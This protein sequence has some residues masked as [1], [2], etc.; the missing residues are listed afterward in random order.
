[1][2]RTHPDPPSA[3]FGLG[4]VLRVRRRVTAS[5]KVYGKT[6]HTQDILANLLK[7]RRDKG[8]VAQLGERL[9]CK[10]EAIGSIPFTSTT[11]VVWRCGKARWA[12]ERGQ[13]SHGACNIE[14]AA[15]SMQLSA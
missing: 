5:L 12:K 2:V 13:A 7:R 11:V 15:L 14:R 10:Q 8:G 4:G 9:L 1:M 6:P 3:W